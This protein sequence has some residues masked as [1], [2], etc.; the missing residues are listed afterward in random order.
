M[1]LNNS[2]ERWGWRWKKPFQAGTQI[3]KGLL[4]TP[5]KRPWQMVRSD[6]GKDKDGKTEESDN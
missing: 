6:G 2:K 4:K 1:S 5:L 3:G